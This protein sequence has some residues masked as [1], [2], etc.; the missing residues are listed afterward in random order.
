MTTGLEAGLSRPSGIYAPV[1]RAAWRRF[2]ERPDGAASALIWRKS[3]K[4]MPRR[5]CVAGMRS[6]RDDFDGGFG[7]AGGTSAISAIRTRSDRLVACIFDI[8]LAR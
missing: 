2:D 1:D 8:T 3:R 6:Y 7:A 4:N 5:V